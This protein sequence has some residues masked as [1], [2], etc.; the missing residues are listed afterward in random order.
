MEVAH[1][2]YNIYIQHSYVVYH[3]YP[4]IFKCCTRY[5]TTFLNVKSGVITIH[6]IFLGKNKNSKFHHH[7]LLSH[8][9]DVIFLELC[10]FSKKIKN[11]DW[12][13]LSRPQPQK[14]S[15]SFNQTFIL[16]CQTFTW[17]FAKWKFAKICQSESACATYEG[18]GRT[19]VCSRYMCMHV[20]MWNARTHQYFLYGHNMMHVK[21]DSLL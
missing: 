13:H 19:D 8:G 16:I 18:I 7:F 17:I 5:I 2:I 12:E 6:Q 4:N 10:T 14:K 15:V 1:Y 9:L 21:E 11:K 20:G 3:T